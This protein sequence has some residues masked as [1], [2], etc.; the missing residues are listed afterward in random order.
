[1]GIDHNVTARRK[2]RP[3]HAKNGLIS[4]YIPSFSMMSKSIISKITNFCGFAVVPSNELEGMKKKVAELEAKVNAKEKRETP[5]PPRESVKRM[6]SAELLQKFEKI[7]QENHGVSAQATSLP[8]TPAPGLAAMH[9]ELLRRTAASRDTVARPQA[10]TRPP[11]PF[12][13]ATLQSKALKKTNATVTKQTGGKKLTGA[14]RPFN[15]GDL[16]AVKLRRRSASKPREDRVSAVN[17]GRETRKMSF[18]SILRNALTDKFKHARKSLPQA[19]PEEEEE[20]D[21]FI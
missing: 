1:M 21:E 10:Q 15:I 11:L 7:C 13:A 3:A 17:K 9:S 19:T 18:T 2:A 14:P 6:S 16:Q 4:K 8:P 12:S 20:E 5:E